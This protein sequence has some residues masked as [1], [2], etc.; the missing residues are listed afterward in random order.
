MRGPSWHQNSCFL[1]ALAVALLHTPTA[2]MQQLL[3][4]ARA[5]TS[6]PLAAELLD[7]QQRLG[8]DAPHTCQ[9]LRAALRPVLVGRGY[10]DPA[11]GG[12]RDALEVLKAVLGHL[13][14]PDVLWATHAA[15]IWQR[16]RWL[17]RQQPQ[18]AR[19]GA[20]WTVQLPT[21]A[22]TLAGTLRQVTEQHV[23]GRLAAE[24]VAEMAAL[25]GDAAVVEATYT[26]RRDE[27]S[28]QAVEGD[29]LLLELE[30][31]YL[32][33]QG[34]QK[35]SLAA[36]APDELRVGGALFAPISLLCHAH[37]HYTCLV[38][39]NGAWWLYDDR[40]PRLGQVSCLKPLLPQVVLFV[41]KKVLP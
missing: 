30:R 39:R 6:L 26:C 37:H 17:R 5:P 15:E 24:D 29:L 23:A 3:M 32:G 13:R 18:T 38:R 1:D 8:K 20:V 19:H 41:Y 35:R 40:C 25:H 31:L 33:A 12:A 4:Q 28:L 7:V 10:E 21:A 9:Q 36:F 16:Q 14:C 11:D 22:R 34:Q 27:R 2:T